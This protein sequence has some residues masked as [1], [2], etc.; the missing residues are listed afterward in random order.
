MKIEKLKPLAAAAMIVCAAATAGHTATLTNADFETRDF[1]GWAI[2]SVNEGVS[3]I[4]EVQDFEVT[5]GVESF[6]AAFMVGRKDF[7]TGPGG[8]ILSQDFEVRRAGVYTFGLDAAVLGFGRYTNLDGGL[9]ELLIDGV[10]VDDFD[11]GQILSA[12][13]IRSRLMGSSFLAEGTSVFAIR[14]TRRYG[15]SGTSPIQFID[16]ASI[17]SAVVPLPAGLPLMLLPLAALIVLRRR[18]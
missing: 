2:S 1:S 14:M 4:S 6:A 17:S 13:T 15:I 16:N 7:A 10:V 9:I 12:Q 11:S 8:L 5:D 18:C 3:T